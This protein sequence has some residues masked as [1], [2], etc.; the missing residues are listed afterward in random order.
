MEILRSLFGRRGNLGAK[1]GERMEID[2]LS[3][4]EG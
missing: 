4:R 1:D 2:H 3:Q